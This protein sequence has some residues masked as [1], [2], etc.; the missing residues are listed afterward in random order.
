MKLVH[1]PGPNYGRIDLSRLFKPGHIYAFN[2]LG[3]LYYLTSSQMTEYETTEYMRESGMICDRSKR[4]VFL[5]LQKLLGNP[6]LIPSPNRLAQ[7]KTYAVFLLDG[8]IVYINQKQFNSLKIFVVE[9][10]E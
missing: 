2:S 6:K 4:F 9:N 8:K 10:E 5:R 3:V 1:D 7:P